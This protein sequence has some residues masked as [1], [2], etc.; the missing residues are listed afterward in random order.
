MLN[1]RATTT[2]MIVLLSLSMA[3]GCTPAAGG[4]GKPT[5]RVGS[6]NFPEQVILAELYSQVLEASGYKVERRMN[7][8]SREIV[9]PAL[10]SGQIDLYP[11]YLATFLT[12]MTKDASK[13]STDA[14]A[15]HHALAEAIKGKNLTVLDFSP[16]VDTNGFVVTRATADRHGLSKL[17]DLAKMNSQ[18][19]LGG[20]PECP[21]RPFCQKGLEEKYGLKF[22]EFRSLDAGGPITVAALEGNQVDVAVLFTTDAAILA[23]G[24]VLLQDDRKL[25]LAD[26]VVPVARNDLISRAPGDFKALL[27]GV[28]AKMTTEE[29]T[30]LNR[31]VGLDRKDPRDVAAAWLKEKGLVR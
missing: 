23:K 14:A 9:A 7:L 16:A 1:P 6:T 29:L 18:F 26:N 25:Q 4:G 20:P 31:Q 2:T 12:F 15:T 27:N 8:G 21:E 3:M 13:A 22:K 19:V 28:S 10:E 24:F 30:A 11:E 5:V 17:S